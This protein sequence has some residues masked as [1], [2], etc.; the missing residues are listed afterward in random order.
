MRRVIK[1][2]AWDEEYKTFSYNEPLHDFDSSFWYNTGYLQQYT[3][4]VDISG[5]DI[6][7]GDIIEMITPSIYKKYK[8]RFYEVRWNVFKWSAFA[9]SGDFE[10]IYPKNLDNSQGCKVVGTI[11]ENPELIK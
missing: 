4:L 9:I 1:F 5:K 11:Y 3:G 2:R 8:V 7:E 6:Y 10:N